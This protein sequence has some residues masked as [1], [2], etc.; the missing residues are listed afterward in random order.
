MDQSHVCVS[1]LS[2][3]VT[4]DDRVDCISDAK[5]LPICSVRGVQCMG[6]SKIQVR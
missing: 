6:A 4:R 5:S 2:V 1:V 3:P